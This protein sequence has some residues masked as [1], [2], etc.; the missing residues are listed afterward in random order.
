MPGHANVGNKTIKKHGKVITIGQDRVIIGAEI[1]MGT[2]GRGF[3]Q[4]QSSVS[5][6]GW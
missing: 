5:C 3:G 1:M 4:W 2:C 6:S